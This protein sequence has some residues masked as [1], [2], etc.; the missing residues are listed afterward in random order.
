MYV[1][2]GAQFCYQYNNKKGKDLILKGIFLYPY[3]IRHYAYLLLALAG[4]GN[5]RKIRALKNKLTQF[6]IRIRKQGKHH[7]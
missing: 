7:A 2:L 3:D 1:L 6:L 4:S 5:Y